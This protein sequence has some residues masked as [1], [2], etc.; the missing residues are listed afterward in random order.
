[1]DAS[2]RLQIG[3]QVR[4]CGNVVGLSPGSIGTIVAVLPFADVYDVK[5]DNLPEPQF[6]QRCALELIRPIEREVGR[7]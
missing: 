3:D 1:L 2:Q 4:T 6:L 7:Q 5:F